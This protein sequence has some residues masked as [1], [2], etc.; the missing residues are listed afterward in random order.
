MKGRLRARIRRVKGDPALALRLESYLRRQDGVIEVRVGAA[1]G[2]V[3][4]L[5]D[6]S[7]LS[8]ADVMAAVRQGQAADSE[9][10]GEDPRPSVRPLLA[11]L[12]SAAAVLLEA[13][14]AVSFGLLA[15]AAGPLVKRATE[16]LTRERKVTVDVLDLSAVGLLALRG[17]ALAAGLS[18]A[19]IEAGEYVRSLT[20][21]R[22]RRA[23]ADLLAGADPYA[24]VLRGHRKLRLAVS[25]VQP[26][27]TVVVYS[28]Q[29]IVVDGVVVAGR[30]QV[31]QK[32]LTGESRQVEKQVGGQVF[33]STVLSD[34]KLYI[35]AEHVGASTRAHRVAQLLQAAPSYDTR[36]TNYARRFADRLV[37]PT[38]ALSACVYALTGDAG[39]SVSILLFDF[40]TG[41][42]V[43][44]PTTIL[45]TMA[46]AARRGVIIKG[47]RAIEQLARADSIIFDKTG[48]LTFGRPVVTRVVP[49]AAATLEEE[50]LAL[51][52]AAEKRLT[53]PVASA[54]VRAAE[55]RNL[56][57]PERDDSH[58]T[59]GLGVEALVNG[60]VVHVGDGRFMQ[61]NGVSALPHL[62][63]QGAASSD[64]LVLVA[65]DGELLGAI[66]YADIP[67]REARDVIA[68]LRQMGFRN[69]VMVT[70]DDE[71][72]A[73]PVAAALG[74]DE[75][76]A[77]V[78]PED[79][80]EIVR[81]LQAKGHVVA[82][83]GD[84]INDSPALAFADVSVS[85]RGGSDIA[86]ET[87][88]IVLEDSLAG[89]PLAVE[90]SRRAMGL[91]Q[92]NLAI[93]ALPNVAGMAMAASGAAGPLLST[94]LNN[95]SSVA[96]ALNGLRPLLGSSGPPVV[97][98]SD[99]Q[100]EGG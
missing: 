18:V 7:V 32:S 44:A 39:R 81:A 75:V 87:A 8:T 47:G 84:G 89:L 12:L 71:D 97:M 60:S 90:L 65:R 93:V 35:R 1:T 2:S 19:L 52:A 45:A 78:F 68:R 43:S 10:S 67:R 48:T 33:A 26:G 21:R 53:H 69:L 27:D 59:I 83:I 56:A 80:A 64:S 9:S 13:P 86:R 38:F 17:N 16:A 22:S 63:G 70:G 72:A 20:S 98:S 28:G 55:E 51:A 82:V 34:G 91:I 14:A 99:R 31:D 46:A 77:N 85:F 73:R 58:F 4:V 54:I 23:V 95:G 94:A 42:R 40:A 61:Q 41:I 88:D 25:D 3:V 15:C 92:Q 100:P 62:N 96:A 66:Y 36:A 30:G 49:L 29:L 11:G 50:V 57:V 24:W 5:F 79:K 37:L 6:A 74:L 76:R